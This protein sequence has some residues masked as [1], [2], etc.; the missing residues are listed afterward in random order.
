MWLPTCNPSRSARRKLA[1]AS[2]TAF[3]FAGRP[4]NILQR[5]TVVPRRRS[6][7]ATANRSTASTDLPVSVRPLNGR[8]ANARALR[9][10][11]PDCATV[12]RFTPP[13]RPKVEKPV[14]TTS[15][16]DP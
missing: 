6:L 9:S 5:S 2:P 15:A 8:I 3:G 11:K 10:T 14:I 16:A 13:T 4:A 1:V 7:D 12:S